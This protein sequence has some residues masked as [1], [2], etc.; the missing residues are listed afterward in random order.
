MGYYRPVGDRLVSKTR[1]RTLRACLE[2]CIH[3]IVGTADIN[4]LR[5]EMRLKTSPDEIVC[6]HSPHKERHLRIAISF[7]TSITKHVTH[8]DLCSSDLALLIKCVDD[9]FDRVFEQARG[10]FAGRYKIS[11]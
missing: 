7:D 4:S 6:S 9:S 8:S 10:L 2:K 11:P 3:I 1:Q 5:P